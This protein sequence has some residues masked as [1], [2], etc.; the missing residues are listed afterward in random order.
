MINYGSPLSGYIDYNFEKVGEVRRQRYLDNFYAS[1]A[2]RQSAQEL[3]AAPF[4][5]DQAYRQELLQGTDRVLSGI[6]ENGDYENMTVAV[7]RAAT[8]YTK[9]AAPLQKN[10]EQY[11][12]YKQELDKLYNEGKIDVEDYQGTMA[13]TTRSYN[14]LQTDEQG[15]VGN[16]F[17]D[18]AVRAIQNPDIPKM[19]KDVLNGMVAD[20]NEQVVEVL[21]QGPDG[22]YQVKTTQGIKR[23][24]PERVENAMR[25]V[26]EDP[27][28][29]TYID[30]KA[31]IRVNNLET[32]LNAQGQ[33][34]DA[35]LGSTIQMQDSMLAE[36]DQAISEASGGSKEALEA[37]RNLLIQS[38]GR[39]QSVLQSGNED[40]IRTELRNIERNRVNAMYDSSAKSRYAYSQ[41]TYKQE[42]SADRYAQ[43]R[44]QQAFEATLGAPRITVTSGAIQAQSGFGSS[45]FDLMDNISSINDQLA[46]MQEDWNQ[47]NETWSEAR[48]D[49]YMSDMQ[50]LAREVSY[51]RA[52]LE[53]R[54]N[55]TNE[56]LTNNEEYQAVRERA[57]RAEEAY[58]NYLS[59]PEQ[60]SL[61]DNNGIEIYNELRAAERDVEEWLRTNKSNDPAEGRRPV[62]LEM[63]TAANIP[64]ID[65]TVAKGIQQTLDQMLQYPPSDM[66]VYAPNTTQQTTVAEIDDLDP[67]SKLVGS[68][69]LSTSTDVPGV[70][71]IAQARYQTEDVIVLVNIPLDGQ[72]QIPDLD[73]HL[74]APYMRAI[75]DVQRLEREGVKR[76]SFP[77][78]SKAQGVSGEMVVDYEAGTVTPI[79]GEH[80]SETM[81]LYSEEFRKEFE[82]NGLELY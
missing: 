63:S 42:I 78:R 5:G 4:E 61:R 12:E 44:Q 6:A 76:H 29:S 74:N 24:S 72:I 9:R 68:V 36:L 70:V 59:N 52:V 64:G 16:Y 38:R 11:T 35:A 81:T 82:K 58:R 13:L 32:S 17:M 1:E 49:S 21:G 27:R 51:H 47:N 20:A 54:Y 43:Q 30:R 65:A 26:M 73:A 80:R 46:T 55:Q 41:D 39:L 67:D 7:S 14:G 2:V 48:R 23:V 79:F 33:T 8:G 53:D 40:D 19:L 28:V 75:S 69:T 77:I 62:D 10:F 25:M 71:I 31:Q 56:D 66:L 45:S 37:Q 18:N 50:R 60:G 57:R 34:I 15:M 22:M 3:E